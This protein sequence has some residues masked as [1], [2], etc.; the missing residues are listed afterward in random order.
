MRD[1]PIN[2]SVKQKD[3]R[4]LCGLWSLLSS[5]LSG[6]TLNQAALQAAFPTIASCQNRQGAALTV[7]KTF[8]EVPMT[9]ISGQAGF[10]SKTLQKSLACMGF[11]P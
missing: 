3:S 8:Q 6:L 7:L 5:A 9:N 2:L 4:L 1:V 11:S 10:E